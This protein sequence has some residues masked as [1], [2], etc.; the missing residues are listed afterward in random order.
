LRARRPAVFVCF[1]RPH[2]SDPRE[3]QPAAA[4]LCGIDQ[5]L[6]RHLPALLVLDI[7]RQ[8]HDVVG[9]LL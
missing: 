1:Q 7:L 8:F 4:G 6:D 5:I 2:H 3:H 9:G